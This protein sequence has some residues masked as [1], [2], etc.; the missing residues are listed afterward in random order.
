MKKKI[1]VEKLQ[2]AIY[3]IPQTL[4]IDGKEYGEC[5]AYWQDRSGQCP[6]WAFLM[7]TGVEIRIPFFRM[8]R[9]TSCEGLNIITID[10]KKIAEHTYGTSV[11]MKIEINGKAEEVTWYCGTNNTLDHYKTSRDDDEE[12]REILLQAFRYLY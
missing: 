10:V 5:V 3:G 12:T 2:N 11:F 6:A 7:D 9:F 8:K 4:T 1:T